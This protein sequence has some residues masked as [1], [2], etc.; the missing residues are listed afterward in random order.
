MWRL[1]CLSRTTAL[2]CVHPMQWLNAA[3]GLRCATHRPDRHRQIHRPYRWFHRRLLYRA[4]FPVDRGSTQQ[5]RWLHCYPRPRNHGGNNSCGHR[6]PS[7]PS[8]DQQPKSFVWQGCS[9]RTAPPKARLFHARG[10][11]PCLRFPHRKASRGHRPAGCRKTSIPWAFHSSRCSRPRPHGPLRGM[12]ASNAPRRP[13][14]WHR[15]GRRWRWQPA[16]QG[17]Q[18]G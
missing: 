11:T 1:R 13:N 17:C 5:G 15:R 4:A 2:R 7:D 14:P 9:A 3:L 12:W 16:R 18:T 6:W 8:S 10:Q